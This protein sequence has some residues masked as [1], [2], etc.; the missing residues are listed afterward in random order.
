MNSPWR[1]QERC[2]LSSDGNVHGSERYNSED[3]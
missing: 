3:Q 2:R 1:E